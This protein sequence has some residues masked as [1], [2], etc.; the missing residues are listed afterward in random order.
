M[1]FS[2][3]IICFSSQINQTLSDAGYLP[4]S[5]SVSA[6]GLQQYTDST[7]Y[8]IVAEIDDVSINTSV[9][10]TLL[11]SADTTSAGTVNATTGYVANSKLACMP[12][13]CFSMN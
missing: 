6:T 13:H 12:L 9:F 1:V 4:K 11:R 8:S 7:V 2:N 3:Y 5:L 10:T